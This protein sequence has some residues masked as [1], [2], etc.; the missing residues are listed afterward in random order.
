MH[1]AL[2]STNPDHDFRRVKNS[3]LAS[4]TGWSF[5]AQLGRLFLQLGY[6][7]LIAR[8]LGVDGYGTLA[9][10]LAVV[11][12]LSPFAGWGAGNLLVMHVARDRSAFPIYWGNV[13]LTAVTSGTVLTVL[14]VVIG[15]WFLPSLPTTLLLG[16]AVA[17]FY[18]G[19][20]MECGVQAFLAVERMVLS[21]LL[22]LLPSALRLAAVLGMLSTN[23]TATLHAWTGWY[24]ASAVAAAVLAMI[25]VT[26]LLGPPLL[27]P[28]MA[29]KGARLG[30]Y[31]AIGQSSA[32]I[33]ADIDKTML[34]RLS[35]LEA[36]GIY[37]AAYR[38][39]QMAG[40]PLRSLLLASYSR[41]FKHGEEGVR[42]S[43]AFATLLLPFALA[44]SAIASVFLFALAPLVTLPLGD[45]FQGSIEAIR[46]LAPVPVLQA[47]H[48]LAA[49]ALTGADK[50]GVRSGVQV[51]VAAANVAANFWL[52]P[53]YGWRGAAWATLLSEG[54]LVLILWTV[55]LRLGMRRNING[56]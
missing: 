33:Y 13:L 49:D 2:K 55:V 44:A 53:L 32:T 25:M 7:V 22:G 54:L 20:L 29:W 19:R 6:F 40:L 17:E 15:Q 24:L 21:T 26:R 46:W 4:N 31:F 35:T 43:A 42:A 37:A 50:Q 18:F 45:G 30:G 36:T 3:T 56:V 39:I 38:A 27:R 16:L 23:G 47:A 5:V 28:A 34:A 51:G 52:I 14:V 12:A 9:A 11:F 41:F 48:Y 1:P 10:A 8:S